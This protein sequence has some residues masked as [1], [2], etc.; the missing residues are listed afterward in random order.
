MNNIYFNYFNKM[1][2]FKKLKLI[3]SFTSSANLLNDYK[4]MVMRSTPSN[5]NEQIISNYFGGFTSVDFIKKFNSPTINNQNSND[6]IVKFKEDN[7][8][9]INS[10]NK[11]ALEGGDNINIQLTKEIILDTPVNSKL[12][13]AVLVIC[14]KN[15]MNLKSNSTLQNI[16]PKYEEMQSVSIK[17]TNQ[18]CSVA[19]LWIKSISDNEK[20]INLLKQDNGLY[21]CPV[22]QYNIRNM[23][24]SPL[25]S[26]EAHKY[27]IIKNRLNILSLLKNNNINNPE[28]T[29]LINEEKT[30]QSINKEK[31]NIANYKNF[32]AFANTGVLIHDK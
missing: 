28:I 15:G 29:E 21:I 22:K 7:D 10:I 2:L 30:I 6:F 3:K 26:F 20:I 13:N 25:H 16:F 17:F 31:E 4:F 12:N 11:V 5:W 19:N 18:K 14:D 23:E 8:I 9:P 1:I 27:K 24:S 32:I